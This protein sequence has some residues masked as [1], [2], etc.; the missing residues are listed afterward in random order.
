[1]V[2]VTGDK[3]GVEMVDFNSSEDGAQRTA[4]ELRT[5][6]E[7]VLVRAMCIAIGGRASPNGRRWGMN[8][9]VG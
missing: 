8:Y 1:M 5:L 9:S 4:D 3:G 2:D 7:D 6:D